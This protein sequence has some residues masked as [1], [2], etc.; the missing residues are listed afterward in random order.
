MYQDDPL[1]VWNP[2]RVCPHCTDWHWKK[3]R[4]QKCEYCDNTRMTQ[5]DLAGHWAPSPAFL[6]CGGP[7]LRHLPVERLRERGVVS[8]GINNAAAFAPCSAFAFGDQQWKFHP[9]LYA[10]GKCLAFVPNGKMNHRCRVRYEDGFHFLDQPVRNYPAVYGYGRRTGF[11]AETFLTDWFAQ[12]GYSR[13]QPDS[14]FTCICS[15]LLGFRLLHYL[16][17]PRVYMIGVDFHNT[18]E[19]PYAWKG[20]RTSGNGRWSKQDQ[21]LKDLRPV[22]EAAGMRVFNANPESKSEAFEQ[23]T[24]A[25]AIA[26]CKGHIQQEPFDLHS[27]DWYSKK[28][29]LADQE[30]HPEFL[31]SWTD[32]R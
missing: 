4:K 11:N 8:L 1:K 23:V 24:W 12:W 28:R 31:Q 30:R 25:E 2:K 7:S 27:D 5:I 32:P 16:G 18:A 6:V 10:D 13:A 21:Y 26:D 20:N 3:R 19:L 22:L 17:C 15:M 14:P 9:S 29:M